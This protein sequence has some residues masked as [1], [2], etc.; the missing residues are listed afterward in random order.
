MKYTVNNKK[1]SCLISMICTY[2]SY[3]CILLVTSTVLTADLYFFVRMLA[4]LFVP[5][6]SVWCSACT[7]LPSATQLQS[8]LL[9]PTFILAE[10]QDELSHTQLLQLSEN[11]TLPTS[12]TSN[13]LT[14]YTFIL[15]RYFY[16]HYLVFVV[17]MIAAVTAI[18]GLIFIFF[19]HLCLCIINY[20]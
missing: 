10:A 16:S 14:F 2:W 5:P 1:K 11:F 9:S 13:Y 12:K 3:P 19:L 18:S 15:F 8:P 17:W 6:G 7:T 20:C 4:G